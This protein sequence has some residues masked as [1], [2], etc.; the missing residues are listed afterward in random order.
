MNTISL[1]RNAIVALVRKCECVK[2]LNISRYAVVNYPLPVT[3]MCDGSNVYARMSDEDCVQLWLTHMCNGQFNLPQG[4]DRLTTFIQQVRPLEGVDVPKVFIILSYMIGALRSNSHVMDIIRFSALS[5]INWQTI[6][7]QEWL[8]FVSRVRYLSHDDTI[9]A[10]DWIQRLDH[11]RQSVNVLEEEWEMSIP[12]YTSVIQWL[13]K[14]MLTDVN[15]MLFPP[16]PFEF[17]V[18]VPWEYT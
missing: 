16:S 17:S 4:V 10:L 11:A 7:Y 3:C 13:P 6:T 18:I 12:D 8:R 2:C 15:E 9:K 1:V 14:E 5:V